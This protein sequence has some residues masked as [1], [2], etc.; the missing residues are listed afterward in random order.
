MYHDASDV[1]RSNLFHNA[2]LQL[3]YVNLTGIK[4]LILH[5]I[6]LQHNYSYELSIHTNNGQ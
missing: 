4:L 1:H 3:K 2:D 6:M 5:D